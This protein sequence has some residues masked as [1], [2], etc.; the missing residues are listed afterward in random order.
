MYL[1]RKKLQIA[2]LT[3]GFNLHSEA[4]VRKCSAK[5]VFLR[6]DGLTSLKKELRHRGFLINFAN[7]LRTRIVK[8]I[9]EWL[10]SFSLQ[11]PV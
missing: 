1:T 11:S 5:R 4:V 2:L 10:L 8:N 3:E 9:S 7:F 6:S